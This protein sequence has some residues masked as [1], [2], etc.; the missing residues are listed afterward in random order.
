MIFL[1][2]NIIRHRVL[3]QFLSVRVLYQFLSVRVLYQFLSVRVLY[4]FLSVRVLYQFLSGYC[5]SSYQLGC[6][7]WFLLQ[8]ENG[9]YSSRDGGFTWTKL[10]NGFKHFRFAGL[11]SV[12]VWV[13]YR[14][15]ASYADW[16]CHEGLNA[17]TFNF[18]YNSTLETIFVVGMLTERGEKARHV[19]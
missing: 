13:D 19:T 2:S 8:R 14:R 16:S 15:T 17:H 3:Y 12:V 5:T 11:G 7:F 9:L 10:D 6:L 1:H 18:L 4:Q